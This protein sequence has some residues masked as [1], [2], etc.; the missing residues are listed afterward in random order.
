MSDF[1]AK[2]HRIQ[3][4]LDVC[5]RVCVRACV[6][7][8]VSVHPWACAAVTSPPMMIPVAATDKPCTETW[9][10]QESRSL[11]QL[12]QR[13]M[14][15]PMKTHSNTPMSCVTKYVTKLV[16][17]LHFTRS[18][19]GL[20]KDNRNCVLS[21]AG[22]SNALTETRICTSVKYLAHLYFHFHPPLTT[23]WALFSFLQ[24]GI[25]YMRCCR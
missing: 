20:F 12:T 6:Q 7:F 3:F 2:M 17:S 4:W 10:Y 21:N 22:L 15:S 11:S 5:V 24:R 8:A 9:A 13:T 19:I 23:R 18:Y 1:K 16:I 14:S 25:S